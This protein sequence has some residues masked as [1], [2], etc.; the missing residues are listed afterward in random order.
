M[1]NKVE[2]IFVS[3]LWNSRLRVL[4]AVL[5]SLLTAI[6]IFYIAAVDTIYQQ[7]RAGPGFGGAGQCTGYIKPG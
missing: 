7:D 5:G 1:L 3:L 4:I 2:K 6:A